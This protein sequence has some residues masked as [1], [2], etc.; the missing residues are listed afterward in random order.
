M[1]ASKRASTCS[2]RSV[3]VQVATI[4]LT[5]SIAALER[6]ERGDVDGAREALGHATKMIDQDLPD[7]TANAL[8]DWMIPL[9]LVRE[10]EN[11]L[12][13]EEN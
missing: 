7:A 4:A 11:L 1:N 3:A 9:A 12:E 13:D 2:G 10:A 6:F 5:Y 8:H